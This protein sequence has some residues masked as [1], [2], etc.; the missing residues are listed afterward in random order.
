MIDDI[1]TQ[2]QAPG[3][4]IVR[5]LNGLSRR[6]K[7]I[8]V[9]R[10]ASTPTAYYKVSRDHVRRFVCWPCL[11]LYKPRARGHKGRLLRLDTLPAGYLVGG[12]I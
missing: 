2:D 7:L 8:G 9:A 6:I 12:L 5:S 3:V 11:W 10:T 1:L 4:I